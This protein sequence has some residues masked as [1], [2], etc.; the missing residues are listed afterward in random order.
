M[1]LKCLFGLF[2][3]AVGFINLF[4]LYAKVSFYAVGHTF[5]PQKASQKYSVERKMLL[6]PTFSL[7]EIN[8][9]LDWEINKAF[10]LKLPLKS[11]ITKLQPYVYFY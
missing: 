5:T 9:K 4:T 10:H 11:K 3:Q 2:H 6:R 1:I 8:P 7:W